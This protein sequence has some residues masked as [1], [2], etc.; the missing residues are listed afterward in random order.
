MASKSVNVIL[1]IVHF[2]LVTLTFVILMVAYIK[3]SGTN[4]NYIESIGKNWNQGPLISIDPAKKYCDVEESRLFNDFWPGTV[5]GCYCEDSILNLYTGG[6]SKGTCSNRRSRKSN[7]SYSRY[8]NQCMDVLETPIVPYTFWGGNSFCGKRI[9]QSYL[10]LNVVEKPELC[11]LKTRSCGIVDSLKNYLCLNSDTPCP[12]NKI[13]IQGKDKAPPTD[14]QY[15]SFQLNNGKNLYYTSENTKGEII[16]DFKFSENQPCLNPDRDNINSDQYLLSKLNNSKGCPEIGDGQSMF[17]DRYSK[18]DTDRLISVYEMNGIE[19]LLQRLPEYKR[20]NDVFT[21]SLYTREYFGLTQEC[22]QK[23]MK[24][25]EGPGELIKS[26]VFFKDNVGGIVSIILATFIISCIAFGLEIC[27]PCCMCTS[28]NPL[29]KIHICGIIF[30]FIFSIT[31]IILTS[32]SYSKTKKLPSNYTLLHGHCSDFSTDEIIANFSDNF[33]VGVK[34]LF[35]ALIVIG[36]TFV[37]NILLVVFGSFDKDCEK[38][39]GGLV[40][41]ENIDRELENVPEGSR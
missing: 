8:V 32:I 7:I 28:E 35:I 5:N 26:L 22:K 15:V 11:P 33:V 31:L 20:T 40:Q 10:D 12:I 13:V 3:F 14:F 41:Q 25:Q 1:H 17:D 21:I 9:P 4:Y 6:L 39:E 36:A 34:L 38:K 2:L 23:I 27:Y 18:I 37:L 30:H 24:S 16:H 19:P 29:A